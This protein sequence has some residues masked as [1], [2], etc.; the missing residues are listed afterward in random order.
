M[1]KDLFEH[2]IISQSER[3]KE[4]KL[5]DKSVGSQ[6]VQENS[7]RYERSQVSTFAKCDFCICQNEVK[8]L[9]KKKKN[10]LLRSGKLIAN[11]KI[12]IV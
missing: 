12:H 1:H 11:Q 10:A 7:M 9:N 8:K 6:Q 5:E 4:R 3:N 2:T